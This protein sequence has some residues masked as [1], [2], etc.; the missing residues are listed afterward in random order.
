MV[1]AFRWP[2]AGSRSLLKSVLFLDPALVVFNSAVEKLACGFTICLN[3]DSRLAPTP[4]AVLTEAFILK[5]LT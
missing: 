3:V 1:R 5:N 4:A 2:N